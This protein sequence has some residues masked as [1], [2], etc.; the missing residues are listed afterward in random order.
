MPTNFDKVIA[1]L[2]HLALNLNVES[3]KSRFKIQKTIFLAQ[4]LGLTTNYCFTIYVGGPYSPGLTRDYYAQ[5]ERLPSLETEYELTPDEVA[6]L[7]KIKVC[8]DLYENLSLM[9]ATATIVY[10]I[11]L[12]PSQKDCDVFAQVKSIKPFLSDSTLVIGISKA[13]ELLFKPEY[14]TDE[15]QK[16]IDSWSNISDGDVEGR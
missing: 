11:K 16:E 2:K 3:Y 10:F 8:S 13:K 6:I 12:N 1:G 5:P 14:L 9:E 15:L 7:E 4:T